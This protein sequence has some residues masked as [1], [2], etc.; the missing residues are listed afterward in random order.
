MIYMKDVERECE[1]S[2]SELDPNKDAFRLE[3][4]VKATG[5][6]KRTLIFWTE[7]YGLSNMYKHSNAGN[8]YG[9]NVVELLLL[10]KKLKDTGWYSGDFIKQTIEEVKLRGIYCLAEL[11]FEK[12]TLCDIASAL[13]E[14]QK[15][16]VTETASV[17]TVL[18]NQ[19][20]SY[21]DDNVDFDEM[22]TEAE[23][24]R[25]N[26]QNEKAREL[27]ERLSQKDSPYHQVAR[28]ALTI[29]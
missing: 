16:P 12:I 8:L 18:E 21:V 27:Y 2:L 20:K 26:G 22:M 14:E 7:E 1:L 19:Q 13:L 15:I 24:Y 4:I 29:I 11:T 9:R 23:I 3:E 5:V 25:Q 17:E 6:K 28:I 10:I